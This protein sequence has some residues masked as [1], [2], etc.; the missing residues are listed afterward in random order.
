MKLP[1][2][3]FLQLAAGAAALP[4]MARLAWAQFPTRPVR[5]IVGFPPGGPS[6]FLARLVGRA[7]SERTGTPV[8]TGSR[9][10]ASGNIA[11]EAVAR[12][13]ADGYMLLLVVPGHPVADV[14]YDKL[15]FNFARDT[16]PV[17]GISNGPLI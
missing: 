2:R 1:R 4:A 10:G 14:L 11:A 16:T 7:G 3:P 12:A 17:A 5:I 6:D 9:P 13:P 15:A 8:I